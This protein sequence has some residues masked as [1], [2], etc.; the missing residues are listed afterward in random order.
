MSDFA[1]IDCSINSFLTQNL[2]A[3]S[4][5]LI[6]Y[7]DIQYVR[8][9]QHI[10]ALKKVQEFNGNALVTARLLTRSEVKV[11]KEAIDY[12]LEDALDIIHMVALINSSELLDLEKQCAEAYPT[13]IDMVPFNRYKLMMSINTILK[14][15]DYRYGVKLNW[16]DT[17]IKRASKQH[18]TESFCRA[19]EHPEVKSKITD[20]HVEAYL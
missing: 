17:V 11:V 20:P 13:N 15:A 1:T 6:E 14:E 8:A 19:L 16:W 5:N 12:L 10:N 7:Y 4:E 9:K 3:D 2:N 18:F